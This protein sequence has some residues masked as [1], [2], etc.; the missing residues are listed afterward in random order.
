MWKPAIGGLKTEV[1]GKTF[2]SNKELTMK[3]DGLSYASSHD[4]QEESLKGFE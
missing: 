1:S 4:K 2:R 3:S